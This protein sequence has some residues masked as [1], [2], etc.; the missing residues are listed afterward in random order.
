MKICGKPN[1]WFTMPACQFGSHWSDNMIM[2]DM[3]GGRWPGPT[4]CTPMIGRVDRVSSLPQSEVNWAARRLHPVAPLPKIALFA[5]FTP[6]T[7][8]PTPPEPSDRGKFLELLKG[9][10]VMTDILPGFISE[11]K[12]YGLAGLYFG[13]LRF[14]MNF[15]PLN[16]DLFTDCLTKS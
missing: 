10:S 16:R 2:C 6:F 4:Q 12:V 11:G 5:S 1:F 3:W 8:H 15:N 9:R 14:E 13:I 7:P